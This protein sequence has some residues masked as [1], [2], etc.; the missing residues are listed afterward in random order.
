MIN[1]IPFPSVYNRLECLFLAIPTHKLSNII[2]KILF[3]SI[4]CKVHHQNIVSTSRKGKDKGEKEAKRKLLFIASQHVF[5]FKKVHPELFYC[6]SKF[7]TVFYSKSNL[8]AFSR[9]SSCL[10]QVL[11]KHSVC[12]YDL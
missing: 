9:L 6:V 11:C 1:C 7:F 4:T 3:L 5:K 12:V 10:I 8:Y 2:F